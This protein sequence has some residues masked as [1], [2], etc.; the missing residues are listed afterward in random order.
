MSIELPDWYVLKEPGE[1]TVDVKNWIE[2]ADTRIDRFIKG[3]PWIINRPTWI[4]DEEWELVK[5]QEI[6]GH[7]LLR[8]SASTNQRIS[9]WLVEVEGDLFEFRFMSSINF[10]EKINVLKD[11]YGEENVKTIQELNEFYQINIYRQFNLADVPSRR[12]RKYSDATRRDLYKR[13]AIRFNKI[14]SVI[15]AKK[16]LLYKGWAVVR[17]SEIRLTVKREFEKQI[18]EV[19]KKSAVFVDEDPNLADTIK[20]VNQKITELAKSKRIEG[21]LSDFGFAGSKE[22]YTQVDCYPPCILDL[23]T[24]LRDKG[25]LAHIENWQ[26]GTF[27]KEVGMPIDEQLKFWYQ[28]SVDN[29]GIT[30]DEFVNRIG[31]QIRHIYGQTG[32]GIDYR[33]PKC[34]T[35][36]DGYYCY[37]AHKKL[38]DISEDIKI[39][40]KDKK[41]EMIDSSIDDISKIIVNNRFQ[42][43]CARYFKLHT[44]WTIKSG[45]INH[46][47]QYSTQA[48]KRFHV[49]KDKEKQSGEKNE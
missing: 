5:V 16:A 41:E 27:L 48:Y 2:F 12:V 36:I 47:V 14:P 38:E 8:L 7:F 29:V 21:S 31:Y 9:G 23:V 45:R 22:V 11:L 43:A 25:H 40:F 15:S 37:F 3:D 30:F 34:K 28:T 13:I 32:G 49:A 19:I 10:D 33:S 44:G 20:P 4:S 46:M 18:S 6:G 42:S 24:I 39:R 1:I 17:I 35:C 26:L